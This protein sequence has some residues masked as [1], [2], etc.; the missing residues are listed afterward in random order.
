MIWECW[1]QIFVKLPIAIVSKLKIIRFINRDQFLIPALDPKT[2]T[3]Y[4]L[5]TAGT[6]HLI[7][8]WRIFCITNGKPSRRSSTFSNRSSGACSGDNNFASRLIPTTPQV[9]LESQKI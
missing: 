2:T 8:I 4:T 5:A 3:I 9:F 7:K 6:D 1:E